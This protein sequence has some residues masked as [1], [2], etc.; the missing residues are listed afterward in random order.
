M[1][2]VTVEMVLLN[3]VFRVT[4]WLTSTAPIGMILTKV[5]SMLGTEERKI[6]LRL[7]KV[8]NGGAGEVPR[9][10][11]EG[12]LVDVKDSVGDFKNRVIHAVV[13]ETN[14]KAGSEEEEG[15]SDE[16]GLGEKLKQMGKK[17]E[18]IG[19]KQKQIGEKQKQEMKQ[20]MQ[21]MKNF[22][23]SEIAKVKATLVPE[24]PVCL[25]QLKPP[26]KIVQCL[27]GH[28]ICEPC[29]KEEA[30]LSCPTCETDFMG[31]DFGMEAFIRDISGEN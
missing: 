29:S 27:R 10:W 20:E 13:V 7:G 1:P 28:K 24:C 30:V 23:R 22:F 2:S 17:L 19:E 6:Q 31:R 11:G 12:P 21:E 18:Q 4:Y 15:V 14:G 16:G 26:K 8:A 9:D 3:R 5:A 25:L